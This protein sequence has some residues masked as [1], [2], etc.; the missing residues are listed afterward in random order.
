MLRVLETILRLA[1]PVIPFVT[2]ALWQAV[3]PLA[4]IPLTGEDSIMLQPYPEADQALVSEEAE[5]WMGQLKALVDATRNLCGEMQLSPSVRVP[6][7]VEASDAAD[8][9]RL[10]GFVAYVQSLGKLS[11]L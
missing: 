10:Q 8:Q 3:A 4:G 2:E 1:H 11:E 9:A 7:I 5:A 6:L